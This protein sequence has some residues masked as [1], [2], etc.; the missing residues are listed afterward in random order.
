[1]AANSSPGKP[2]SFKRPCMSA[3]ELPCRE[4]PLLDWS[5]SSCASGI[6]C[7]S[8]SPEVVGAASLDICC[9]EGA[10]TCRE[11]G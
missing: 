8:I 1:M 9:S 3:A 6:C 11:E 5:A 2:P 7:S 10:A 4:A